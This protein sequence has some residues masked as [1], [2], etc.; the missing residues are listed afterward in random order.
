M[1]FLAP[2]TSATISTQMNTND[3][4]KIWTIIN[5]YKTNCFL[6]SKRKL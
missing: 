2:N 4:C 3:I 1:Y 5:S 6:Q